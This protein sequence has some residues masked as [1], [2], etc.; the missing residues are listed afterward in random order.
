MHARRRTLRSAASIA[1][2]LVLLVVVP[3]SATP[4]ALLPPL[5][6]GGATVSVTVGSVVTI[7]WTVGHAGDHLT[8]AIVTCATP[9]L[10]ISFCTGVETHSGV[11]DNGAFAWNVPATLADDG[12]LYR[13][14]L[15]SATYGTTASSCN[16][17]VNPFLRTVP[18]R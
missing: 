18:S 8:L 1:A 10:A 17:V 4:L 5:Q 13:V 15:K 12:T 2:A 6:S 9:D 11:T 14:F 16:I 7:G 3:V